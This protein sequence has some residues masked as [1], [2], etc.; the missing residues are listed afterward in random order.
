[1]AGCGGA[2][3]RP[4]TWSFISTA[5]IQPACATANCHSALVQRAS[6]DLSTRSVG[7]QTLLGRSFVTPGDAER[8]EIIHLMHADGVQRMPPDSPLPESDIQLI[9]AWITD[10]AKNN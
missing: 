4:A 10:G 2:D 9:A 6:V 5:I 1:L 3:D 8:S 7:Y